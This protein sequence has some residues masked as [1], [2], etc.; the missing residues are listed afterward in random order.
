[1]YSNPDLDF[2]FHQ[3]TTVLSLR[4]GYGVGWCWLRES[5]PEHEFHISIEMSHVTINFGNWF[6]DEELQDANRRDP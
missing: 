1:M 2:S 5:C 6:N 3:E 4:L